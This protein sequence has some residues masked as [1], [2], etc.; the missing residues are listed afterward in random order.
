MSETLTMST[1]ERQM[2]RVLDR[3]R[4]QTKPKL[5]RPTCDIRHNNCGFDWRYLCG[6]CEKTSQLVP[7]ARNP[8]I[9]GSVTGWSPYQRNKIN[10]RAWTCSP[11]VSR[12][13]L[14]GR[15]SSGVKFA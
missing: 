9:A 5:L 1:K 6:I 4:C 8:R 7:I 2:Y 14:R 11:A 12:Y 13:G 15:I 10:L 3:Y